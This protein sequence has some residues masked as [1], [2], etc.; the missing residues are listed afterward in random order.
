MKTSK[1]LLFAILLVQPIYAPP[2]A[3]AQQPDP[4]C[5]T[6]GPSTADTLAYINS[7]LANAEPANPFGHARLVYRVSVPLGDTQIVV[8]ETRIPVIHA[9]T[10]TSSQ[11]VPAVALKCDPD[12]LSWTNGIPILGFYC[13]GLRNCVAERN[14]DQDASYGKMI[15]LSLNIDSEQLG[16]LGRA[17]SHLIALLQKQY[18]ETHTDTD[19]FSK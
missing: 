14:P 17:F 9:P 16:R 8:T 6:D 10:S 12:L 11:T 5:K 2:L 15:V 7:T 18:N 3:N 1:Y 13:K 4:A 19:P